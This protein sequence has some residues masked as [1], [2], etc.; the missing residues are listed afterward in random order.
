MYI[1]KCIYYLYYSPL[2]YIDPVHANLATLLVQLFQDSLNE[3][4]YAADI[5]GLKYNLNTTAYGV[6]VSNK[7]RALD[8]E[9][10]LMIIRDNF[11]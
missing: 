1:N 3:Y 7:Y 5:A 4:T 11:C 6:T 8:K 2:V 9:E 10:Y